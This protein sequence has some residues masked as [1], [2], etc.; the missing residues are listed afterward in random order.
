MIIKSALSSF[1]FQ[2]W[3]CSME[4]AMGLFKIR[5]TL[6]RALVFDRCPLRT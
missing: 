5:S 2:Q 6:P 3:R 4:T 1:V